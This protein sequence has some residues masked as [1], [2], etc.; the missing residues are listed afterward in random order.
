[1]MWDNR[2]VLHR[3]RRFDLAQHRELRRTS[4]E[5]SPRDSL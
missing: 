3:G 1:V 5:D 2:A 4:T